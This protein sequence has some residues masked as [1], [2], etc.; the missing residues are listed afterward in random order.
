M[1][2]AESTCDFFASPLVDVCPVGVPAA[3][4]VVGVVVAVD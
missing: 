3:V 2:R 1:V 4:V